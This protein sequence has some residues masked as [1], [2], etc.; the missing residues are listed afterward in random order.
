MQTLNL[1]SISAETQCEG[2][3]PGVHLGGDAPWDDL[4]DLA[5]EQ[6]EQF[7]H[8]VRELRLNISIKKIPHIS[9]TNTLAPIYTNRF[10]SRPN[11]VNFNI[12]NK[13]DSVV[14]GIYWLTHENPPV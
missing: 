3:L 12:V 4:E 9:V 2:T 5:A 7:V 8:C 13:W 1:A 14:A 11:D 10:R 6:N